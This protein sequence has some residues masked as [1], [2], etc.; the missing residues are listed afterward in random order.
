MNATLP[1]GAIVVGVDGTPL[2]LRAV[3]WA[4]HQAARE[5]RPLVLAYGAGTPPPL[6]GV[7]GE[8][9]AVDDLK[10]RRLAGRRIL[11]RAARLVHE[12]DPGVSVSDVLRVAPAK[13]LLL[14]LAKDAHLVVVGSRGLGPIGS[15]ALGSVSVAVASGAETPVVVVREHGDS[16]ARILVGS[17]GTAASSDALEFAFAQASARAV[18]LTVAHTFYEGAP[19][20]ESED[21]LRLAESMAGLREKYVEVD[22]TLK[23]AR[24][25][26]ADYLIQASRDADL[27]VVGARGHHGRAGA[28]LGSVSQNVIEKARC[29]VAVVHPRAPR[30]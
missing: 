28:L 19:R 15:L 20:A 5:R 9:L 30:S 8:T 17:D 2:N 27:V 14:G 3:V 21:H 18:P 16:P 24:G 1:P 10:K 13:N 26:A 22:V 29:S 12:T 23:V 4:T 7:G 25:P 6:I 11:N